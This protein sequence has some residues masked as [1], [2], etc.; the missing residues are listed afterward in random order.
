VKKHLASAQE[1]KK[2]KSKDQSSNK[3]QHSKAQNPTTGSLK[4]KNQI[5]YDLNPSAIVARSKLCKEMDE[6]PEKTPSL[7]AAS[8]HLTF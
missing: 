1:K 7:E 6:K 4:K 2:K 8:P 3:R 5:T